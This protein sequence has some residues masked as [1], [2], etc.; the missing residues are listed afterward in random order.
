MRRAVCPGSFDPI[1]NG[2]LEVIARAASLFD[3]VIVAVSTNYAKKYRFPLEERIEM[4]RETLASLRGIVVEPVGEGLLA[5]YCRQRGVSAIVKG[6]RSSSDFDYELP[7]A[8]M[9][10][11]LS[12]VETVFLP[13]E[14]HYL[15]LSS[16]LIKE[17]ATLGG[18]VSEY[19]PRSVLKRLLAGGAP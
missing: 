1:H 4:A 11:Q 9:N 10:R 8:T 17:V 18:S 14:A 5:E 7:M 2:H 13:A 12:G 15:H 19:V 3:E 16:T 6:L